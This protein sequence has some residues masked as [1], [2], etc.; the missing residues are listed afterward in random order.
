M[1]D[2]FNYCVTLKSLDISNFNTSSVTN[3]W[4]MFSACVSL[5]SLDLSNFNTENVTNMYAMF[6]YCPLKVLDLSSFNTSKV[7]NM[8]RLLFQGM[9]L[10]TVQTMLK[11]GNRSM[12]VKN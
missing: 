5:E 9:E 4:G 12:D 3:M 1:F 11:Q 2:M 10:K 8:D 7:T 6:Q